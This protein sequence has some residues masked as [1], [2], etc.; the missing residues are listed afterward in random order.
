MGVFA[1]YPPHQNNYDRWCFFENAFTPEECD[2]ILSLWEQ[3]KE[4]IALVGTNAEA[5]PDK[6]IRDSKLC[7]IDHNE[8]TDW[9]FRKLTDIIVPCNAARY[10]FDLSGFLEKIQLTKYD[11]NGFY[12]WHEDNGVGSF[13]IRKLS[14]IIQLT[15]ESAYEGGEVEIFG[16]GFLKK[17][18]GTLCIFPSY[19]THQVLPVTKGVRH[20]LVAWVSGPPFR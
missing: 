8:T 15:D 16:G 3:P 18:R 7:W 17:S 14:I 4:L 11:E 2:K 5:A 1:F 13:S 9:L 10:K 20:S 12:K 19:V 6:D